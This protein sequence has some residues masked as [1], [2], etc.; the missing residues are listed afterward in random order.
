MIQST[1]AMQTKRSVCYLFDYIKQHGHLN[2]VKIV[3]IM[4]DEA[5]LEVREDLVEEY[6]KV[7]SECMEKGGNYYLESGIFS[8]TAKSSAGDNWAEIK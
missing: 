6:L 7:L 1:A 2:D 4:H 3:Q 8:M 5:V